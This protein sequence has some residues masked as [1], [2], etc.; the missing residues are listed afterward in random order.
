MKA[1]NLNIAELAI[2]TILCY[3][4]NNA[5]FNLDIFTIFKYHTNIFLITVTVN[6]ELSLFYY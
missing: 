6:S 1:E 4:I 3:Y 5:K 2:F